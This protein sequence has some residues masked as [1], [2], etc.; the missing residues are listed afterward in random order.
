MK[1]AIISTLRYADQADNIS[2]I[3]LQ[4]AVFRLIRYIKP[5][6]VCLSGD[7]LAKPTA[8]NA[9]A[10]WQHLQD[11]LEKLPCP[12]ITCNK[13]ASPMMEPF[14]RQLRKF[15]E[16]PGV[17]SDDLQSIITQSPA[18]HQSPFSFLVVDLN[19]SGT[20]TQVDTCDLKL[21]TGSQ[22]TDY[23]IH[24]PVAYCS[25][26]LEM[27]KTVT[28]AKTFGLEEAVIVEHSGQLYYNSPDYWASAYDQGWPHNKQFDRTNDF[29]AEFERGQ[30][31]ANLPL[32]RG[33]E[34]DISANGRL[35]ATQGTLQ[36]ARVR[37]GSIHYLHE[38]SS[39][40]AMKQEYMFKLKALLDNGIDIFAHPF[41]IF[42]WHELPTPTDLFKPVANLLKEYEVA[43]EL[44]FHSN[45]PDPDFFD[46]CLRNSVKIAFGSDSHQLYEIGEFYPH[47]QLLKELDVLDKLPEVTIEFE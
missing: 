34:L 2:D 13:S 7:L 43:A 26:D 18:L 41:R 45:S 27:V 12:I 14:Y 38:K 5:D 37:L 35:V 1:L 17:M 31:A 47:L 40:P 33:L 15:K 42:K 24:T 22:L 30:A 44:N 32:Q 4:R 21:P 46:L 28:L 20:P 3:L 29:L 9:P 19:E 16:I 39:L 25:E 36:H 11:I 10:L 8:S 6:A 23:H